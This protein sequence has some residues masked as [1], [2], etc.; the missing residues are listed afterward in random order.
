MIIDPFKVQVDILPRICPV[1]IV[2]DY[3]VDTR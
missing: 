3:S 2:A 1:Y